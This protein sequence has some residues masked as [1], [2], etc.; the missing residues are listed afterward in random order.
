[1]LIG[2]RWGLRSYSEIGI[3]FF[4]G[5]DGDESL[6]AVG[7]RNSGRRWSWDSNFRVL[8]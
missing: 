3:N 2:W 5:G 4:G 7:L 6:F 1:M 8:L